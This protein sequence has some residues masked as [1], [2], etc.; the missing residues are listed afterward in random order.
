MVLTGFADP[1]VPNLPGEEAPKS[2]RSAA[3][4]VPPAA[5]AGLDDRLSLQDLAGMIEAGRTSE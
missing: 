3:W 4:S 2:E 1:D 5:L